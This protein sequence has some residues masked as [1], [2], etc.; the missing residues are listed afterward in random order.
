MPKLT[1]D[2]CLSQHGSTA[3]TTVYETRLDFGM[4]YKEMIYVLEKKKLF[5]HKGQTKCIGSILFTTQN[6]IKHPFFS[7][8]GFCHLHSRFTG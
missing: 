6:N 2:N 8:W 5:C 3:V 7:I 1:G 4:Q